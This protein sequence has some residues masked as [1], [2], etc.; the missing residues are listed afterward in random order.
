M[1]DENFTDSDFLTAESPKKSA[2][3]KPVAFFISNSYNKK[4][5]PPA[6]RL[7]KSDFMPVLCKIFENAD[8]RT[9]KLP[10]FEFKVA[11]NFFF[12]IF[13]KISLQNFQKT[14]TFELMCVALPKCL[15]RLKVKALITTDYT[16]EKFSENQNWS[17]VPPKR[18]T[19]LIQSHICLSDELIRIFPKLAI[20]DKKWSIRLSQDLKAFQDKHK[21][22]LSLEKISNTTGQFSVKHRGKNKT[23]VLNLW[24]PLPA[25]LCSTRIDCTEKGYS[26]SLQ[27]FTVET[28]D[29]DDPVFWSPQN[30]RVKA[31]SCKNHRK[32][33]IKLP[34]AN[35]EKNSN[36]RKIS[37]DSELDQISLRENFLDLIKSLK[38]KPK[39]PGGKP[40]G[41]PRLKRG[42]KRSILGH[43][44]T[45]KN[46]ASK[47]KLDTVSIKTDN[48]RNSRRAKK[49]SDR[50][51]FSESDLDHVEISEDFDFLSSKNIPKKIFS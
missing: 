49:F 20:V 27:V 22:I 16:D 17:I 6:K 21:M 33:K 48:F 3:V 1:K 5:S 15:C 14:D 39:T 43:I 44:P 23:Y 4:R 37:S 24:R 18:K 26:S 50:E 9:T 32:S 41:R 11:D 28:V 25:L 30:W 2:R 46:R 40:I 42:R 47:K 10:L 19:T 51:I 45:T 8:P 7:K 36:F 35:Y 31:N 12:Y 34:R 38:P 29:P 13:E